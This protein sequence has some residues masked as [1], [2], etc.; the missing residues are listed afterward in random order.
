[1]D[2]MTVLILLSIIA[3]TLLMIIGPITEFRGKI[4]FMDSRQEPKKEKRYGMWIMAVGAVMFVAGC[5]SR[6]FSSGD[7]VPILTV[8]GYVVWFLGGFISLARNEN[9]KLLKDEGGDEK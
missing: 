6:E 5:L 7:I 3:S 4:L 8:G 2:F 1:M 9:I